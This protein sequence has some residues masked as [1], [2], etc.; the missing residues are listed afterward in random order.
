VVEAQRL[1]GERHLKLRLAR[2]GRRFDAILFRHA[3]PLPARI[4]GAYRLGIDT[5][6]GAATVQLALEDW[7]PLSD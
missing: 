5:W 6:N 4:R 2:D 1:V 3:E 7:E